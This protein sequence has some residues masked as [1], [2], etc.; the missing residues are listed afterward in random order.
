M[1]TAPYER[2]GR[3]TNEVSPTIASVDVWYGQSGTRELFYTAAPPDEL[4][5]NRHGSGNLRVNEVAADI[6]TVTDSRIRKRIIVLAMLAHAALRDRA[7]ASIVVMV[8]RE[9]EEEIMDYEAIGFHDMGDARSDPGE[10]T[11]A[12]LVRHTDDDSSEIGVA[13]L[14]RNNMTY[15]STHE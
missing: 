9:D 1:L 7:E 13:V 6:Y 11:E 8:P 14:K 2:I 3:Y 10:A 4:R 12:I 15:A 5:T